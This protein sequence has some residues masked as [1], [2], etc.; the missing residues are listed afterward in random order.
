M[1]K[2]TIK[3]LVKRLSKINAIGALDLTPLLV[4][5]GEAFECTLDV[6]ASLARDYPDQAEAIERVRAFMRARITGSEERVVG[7]RFA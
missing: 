5:F 6:A 7:K 4:A 2:K 1:K 3:K